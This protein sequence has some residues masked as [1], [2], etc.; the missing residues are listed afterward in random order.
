MHKLKTILSKVGY[1][2]SNFTTK[3]EYFQESVDL[4]QVAIKTKK[5]LNTKR[6]VVKNKKNTNYRNLSSSESNS[7]LPNLRQFR[8]AN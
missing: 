3:K 1:F 8:M 6:L 2:L 4:Q 7:F 5:I